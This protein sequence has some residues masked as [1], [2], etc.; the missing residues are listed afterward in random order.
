L[1]GEYKAESENKNDFII[2]EWES[3]YSFYRTFSLPSA[4]NL[5]NAYA[6]LQNGILTVQIPKEQQQE[7]NQKE[8]QIKT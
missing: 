1:S 6:N 2:N 7:T 3:E 4:V 5:D 8:I